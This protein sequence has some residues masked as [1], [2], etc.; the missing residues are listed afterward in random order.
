[1]RSQPHNA[2]TRYIPKNDMAAQNRLPGRANTAS[3]VFFAP[4]RWWPRNSRRK[5]PRPPGY[6]PCTFL[7]ITAAAS[8]ARII[9]PNRAKSPTP[10]RCPP[11][12][13]S[14]PSSPPCAFRA[15][16]RGRL[17]PTPHPSSLRLGNHP[18]SPS[19]RTAHADASKSAPAPVKLLPCKRTSLRILVNV[20][21]APPTP[22]SPRSRPSH[23]H[24]PCTLPESERC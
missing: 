22:V 14:E 9:P 13:V 16:Q 20:S 19:R 18:P 7:N 23:L 6:V 5:P 11:L 2:T 8:R 1:M 4:G 10:S 3:Q 17:P 15:A 21:A 12:A 24:L